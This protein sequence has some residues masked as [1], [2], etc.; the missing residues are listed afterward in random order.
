MRNNIGFYDRIVRGIL[1]VLLLAY[2]WYAH[3]MLALGFAIFVFYEALSSWCAFYGVIGTN[4]C[5]IKHSVP[6][7]KLDPRRFGL[8][9]G[10][11]WGIGIFVI[12]LAGIYNGYGLLWSQLMVDTYPG[13]N[14][15]WPG[16]IKGLLWG[17]LDGFFCL[18]L[19]A[20]LYNK[21]D[22]GES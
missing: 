18:F 20:W 15:T 11:L 4:T 22:K 8:A 21:L 1:G 9:G 10:I 14:L 7:S 3:S 6:A 19:L 2:A 12:C 16:A 13:Y 17:F 5:P